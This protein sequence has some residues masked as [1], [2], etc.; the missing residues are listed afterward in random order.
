MIRKVTQ[1]ESGNQETRKKIG[2][3]SVADHQLIIIVIGRQKLNA[4]QA[5]G[6]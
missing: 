1:N 3:A 6:D 2:S 4:V 5:G